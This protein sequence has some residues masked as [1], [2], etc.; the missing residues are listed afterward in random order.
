MREVGWV[1][2]IVQRIETA[3]ASVSDPMLRRRMMVYRLRTLGYT[4]HAIAEELNMSVGTAHADMEWCYK[5]L[6]PAY[7]TAD[8]F[9]FVAISQL[10]EQ[11]QRIV[12]PY[13]VLEQT[14]SGEMV[15]R[16][17]YPS[18]VA[19]KV[20]KEIKA[21]QAKLLGAYKTASVEE[22]PDTVTYTV[23]VSRQLAPDTF[24]EQPQRAIEG[25]MASVGS[26][27]QTAEDTG[28]EE[29]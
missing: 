2:R 12:R 17:Q 15:E 19:E 23:T 3:L 21:E 14:E 8:E 7:Q 1:D 27:L 6:P 20:A 28:S 4:I 10:E 11:Y 5:N 18:L 26:F 13:V 16:I 24:V 25:S 9:R 29:V 22:G